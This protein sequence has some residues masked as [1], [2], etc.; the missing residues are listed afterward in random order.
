VATI[1]CPAG[2]IF[3]DIET[4][5]PNKMHLI[6]DVKVDGLIS[7]ILETVKQ[8]EDIEARITHLILTSGKEV[9][10]CP[11]CGRILI[12]ETDNSFRSFLPEN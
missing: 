5:N 9:Y 8:G 6:A 11:T 1:H 4:P 10:E 3:A 2:H 12:L 7:D